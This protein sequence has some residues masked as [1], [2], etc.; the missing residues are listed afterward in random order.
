MSAMDKEAHVES[1]IRTLE[2]DD[3]AEAL[4]GVPGAG[5][6]LEQRN[7][8]AIGLELSAK[9]DTLLLDAPTSGLDGQSALVIGRLLRKLANAGQTVLC[10]IH[11]P[12]AE[13][14]EV[15]DHLVLL[16][17]GGQLAYDGPLG[18][19]CSSALEYF[20]RFAPPCG[21]DENPEE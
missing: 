4:I 15:F 13:L 6:N 18:N 21:P 5:L 7:R 19:G 12:A 10:T 17:P 11:Q 14:M 9:P 3:I 2:M 8:V 20:A 16:V 1:V